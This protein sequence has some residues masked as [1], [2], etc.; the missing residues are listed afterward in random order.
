M[1]R[2]PEYVWPGAK[3]L[4]AVIGFRERTGDAIQET[5]NLTSIPGMQRII[6]QAPGH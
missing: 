5:L 1:S 4:L 6:V 2:G 3:E